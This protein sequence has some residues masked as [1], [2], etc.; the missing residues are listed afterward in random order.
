MT[1]IKI[2][3]DCDGEYCGKCEYLETALGY[4]LCN[5][6]PDSDFDQFNGAL[7]KRCAQCLAA[8][9]EE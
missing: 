9:V 4:V 1:Q 5:L 8:T 6:F 3:I 7:V 2:S